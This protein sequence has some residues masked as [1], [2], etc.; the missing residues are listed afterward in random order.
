MQTQKGRQTMKLQEKA[1]QEI[2]R[3]R[4]LEV[5]TQAELSEETGIDKSDISK[6]ERG[7]HNITLATLERIAT[8]LQTTVKIIFKKNK[9]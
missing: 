3:M 6:Y 2:K 9:I 1:G 4:E 8:A 7:Q 5:M